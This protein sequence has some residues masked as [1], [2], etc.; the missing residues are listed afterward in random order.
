MDV[1]LP[2]KDYLRHCSYFDFA[3]Q[4]GAPE[5]VASLW[6]GEDHYGLLFHKKFQVSQE[7][8]KSCV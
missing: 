8:F 1:E 7:D 2:T 5:G 6:V 4:D 3:E